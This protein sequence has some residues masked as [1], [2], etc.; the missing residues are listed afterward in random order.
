MDS[1][2]ELWILFLICCD[3]VICVWSLGGYGGGKEGF[4]F[5]LYGYLGFFEEIVI[6]WDFKLEDEVVF[7]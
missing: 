3:R 7:I 5:I 4:C 2:G 1:L 6:E